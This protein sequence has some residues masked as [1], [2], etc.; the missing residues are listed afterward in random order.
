MEK[1]NDYG[2]QK[3]VC[4]GENIPGGN[5]YLTWFVII[6]LVILA[7]IIITAIHGCGGGGGSIYGPASGNTQLPEI[8]EGAKLQATLDFEGKTPK[9]IC[10]DAV[11]SNSQGMFFYVLFES[12]LVKRY[13]W[14]YK[15]DTDYNI[16]ENTLQEVKTITAGTN[17][18]RRLTNWDGA[19]EGFYVSGDNK[20]VADIWKNES[21]NEEIINFL[22]PDLISPT[23]MSSIWPDFFICDSGS[24]QIFH[25][26]SQGHFLEKWGKSG[27]NDGELNS[28]LDV[29]VGDN[30]VY[31]VDTGNNRIQKFTYNGGFSTKWGSSGSGNGELD[32]P[33]ALSVTGNH[34]YVAD[35]GNNRIQRFSKEGVFEISWPSV[36]SIDLEYTSPWLFVVEGDGRIRVYGPLLP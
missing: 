10:I 17:D 34:V 33:Q 15:I 14:Q 23:G 28:P 21:G 30:Y 29:D 31:V 32:S 8:I 3:N 20:V 2:K 26:S 5:S 12:N 9:S 24:N 22:H 1:K 19:G 16:T 6:V 27:S 13:E 18:C 4:H 35:T 11:Y 7:F 36:G 25:F